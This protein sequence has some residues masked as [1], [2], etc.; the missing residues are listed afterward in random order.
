MGCQER[1]HF[2]INNGEHGPRIEVN[3]QVR[4]F[5]DDSHSELPEGYDGSRDATGCPA[6]VKFGKESAVRKLWEWHL[7]LG[8]VI[9]SQSYPSSENRG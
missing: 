5:L 9:Y 1:D 7:E 2:V 4:Q 6:L 8:K 3:E